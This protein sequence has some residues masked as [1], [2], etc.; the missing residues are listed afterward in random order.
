[1][2]PEELRIVVLGEDQQV[3]SENALDLLRI[4]PMGMPWKTQSLIDFIRLGGFHEGS[5][6]EVSKDVD[7][8]GKRTA[9]YFSASWCAPCKTFTPK[10]IKA[11]EDSKA[12]GLDNELLFVSLDQEEEAFDEYRSKMPWPCVRAS[13]YMYIYLCIYIYICIY[14]YVSMS[15]CIYIFTLHIYI[16]I[17]K[18]VRE[19]INQ[20]TASGGVLSPPEQ[21]IC[22]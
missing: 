21:G 2:K 8:R 4:N 6:G 13:M 9:L 20:S 1:V 22:T 7:L 5:G 11:Y 14:I 19:C 17:D 3:V 15:L 18:A 12:K 16:F 10:L